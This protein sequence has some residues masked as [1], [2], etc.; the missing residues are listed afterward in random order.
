MPKHRV[1]LLQLRTPHVWLH[2]DVSRETCSSI[3]S[4]KGP[5]LLDVRT[6]ANFTVDPRFVP[7]SLRRDSAAVVQWAPAFAGR[8]AIVISQ[9]GTKLCQGVAASAAS[10]AAR[11][12]GWSHSL[13]RAAFSSSGASRRR[14]KPCTSRRAAASERDHCRWPASAADKPAIARSREARVADGSTVWD[15]R[16]GARLCGPGR[17]LPDLFAKKSRSTVNWPILAWSFSISRSCEASGSAPALG[18]NT[19]VPLSSNCFF[20]L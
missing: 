4:P 9:R 6:E 17:Y 11:A 7:G 19:R 14:A 12:C 13:R 8:S 18:S 15:R 20:Q 16:D 2:L 10:A 3:G 5:V 1:Q